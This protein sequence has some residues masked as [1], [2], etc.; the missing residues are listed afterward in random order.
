MTM[1]AGYTISPASLDL[2][3]HLKDRA[4]Q[5]HHDTHYNYH[6]NHNQKG[7]VTPVESHLLSPYSSHLQSNS[8]SPTGNFNTPADSVSTDIYQSSDFSSSEFSDAFLTVD[9]D[10][11]GS[12]VPQFLEGFD[13]SQ[14]SLNYHTQDEDNEVINVKYPLSPHQTPCIPSTSAFSDS[15]DASTDLRASAPAQQFANQARPSTNSVDSNQSAPQLTP[16]TNGGS[17]SSDDHSAPTTLAMAT[18]SPRVTVSMWNRDEDAPIQGVERSFTARTESSR[19][20]QASH[21]LAGDLAG[22]PT[23]ENIP[24]VLRDAHGSWIPHSAAGYRGLAPGDRPSGEVPSPNQ[25][26]SRRERDEKNKEV[27]DWVWSAGNPNDLSGGSDGSSNIVV[28]GQGSDDDNIPTGEIPLGNTTENKHL[29]GQAYLNVD[30]PGGPLTQADFDIMRQLPTWGDAPAIHA[31][32]SGSSRY[33]PATSQAAIEK[34]NRQCQDNESIVSRAATWGTRR[35]SLPSIV[36][37]EGIVSGNFLKKLSISGHTRRPSFIKR[38]PSL[39]RKPSASQIL[40][41]KNSNASDV[42]PEESE[43]NERRRESKDTLAPPSRTS[44]WGISGISGISKKPTPS[45]NTALVGMA[46]GAASIGTT[47]AR[48]GSISATSIT[49]PK[50]PFGSLGPPVKNA[51][52]R[53]RS[54]TE[55]PRGS[56]PENI[57]GMLKKQGG[58]PV[59]SLA[60]TKPAVEQDEDEDEDDEGF[61]DGDIKTEPNRLQII[62][63]TFAGFRSHIM[64]LN[65][66]FPRENSWLADRIAHQMVMRYK[67]LQ[68]AKVRHLNQVKQ[69]KCPCGPRCLSLGGSAVSLEGRGGER[70]VDPLSARPDS[71]DGDTNPLEGGINSESFPLGIPMP[72]I[73]SLPAEFECQLCFASKKFQKP[74]DWTKHVHEDVQPFTCT[75][76]KCR[77]PK[78]FKR[79]ADWVRHENEGHRHLEWWLCDVDDCR[80]VCYRRDNFLQHLVREHKYTEPKIKTKAAIKKAGGGDRTWMKVESCHVETQVKPSEE[81]CRF[82]RK[83]FPTWKKLTVHLAKHM[84]HISLPVL[85]VVKRKELDADTVI[86][87]IQDPPRPNFPVSSIKQEPSTFSPQSASMASNPISMDYTPNNLNYGMPNMSLQNSFYG[88]H[89]MAQQY[90]DMSPNPGTNLMTPNYNIPQPPQPQYHPLP[91]T[92]GPSYGSSAD[93]YTNMQPQPEGL[94]PFPQLDLNPL[95]IQEPGGSFGYDNLGNPAMQPVEQYGNHPGSVSPYGHSPHQGHGAFYNP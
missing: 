47:H 44:S 11:V 43:D 51:L 53:R 55:L 59:A 74:S 83:T 87:P 9:F 26:A 81:P 64:G 14:D 45:L 23:H 13:D 21:S 57:I 31:I 76:E 5:T 49:S 20:V 32:Q 79:K 7:P 94:E 58:P 35:R 39:V 75:W 92:T 18:Q 60:R 3:D 19:A 4:Q 61:D 33:Q 72:P 17:F 10:N 62:E 48:S 28:G 50:S 95:G 84:E 52:T 91:V 36:D 2:R 69:Q 67:Q 22:D 80:H 38:F 90:A 30:A 8:A 89:Q 73:M 70:G 29:P 15:V 82:C 78:M 27:F 40:K 42:S 46:T 93:A 66:Q 1:S 12:G 16:D 41:R 25:Q 65:P 63:P 68:S 37:M 77:D 6:Y 54:K 56:N 24:N 34:F 85:D 86:S 71:S 88:Q